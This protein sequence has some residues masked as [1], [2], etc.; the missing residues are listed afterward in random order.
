M[1]YLSFT[2]RTPA[3]APR[4]A[5]RTLLAAFAIASAVCLLGAQ[6]AR[7]Q[8]SLERELDA[9]GKVS[10]K[11]RNFHGR[12]TVVASEAQQKVSV[13]AESPARPLDEKELRTSAERGAVTVEVERGGLA[14][15]GRN[16]Y[17]ADR[18]E[19]ERDRVDLTVRVPQ[20]AR[21]RVETRGGA[22]EIVGNVESAEV[23]TDTGT[24]RA[25]VP[26]ESVALR[27]SLK[28][29]AAR[30]RFYSEIELPKVQ[31]RRG[32]VFEI[33]GRVGDKKAKKD[34]RIELDFSTER[35]V[36][37]FGVSDPASVPTDLR[38]RQLTEAARAVIRSGNRDLIDAIRKVA[39]R[40]VGDYSETLPP[41]LREPT[42]VRGRGTGH[43]TARVEQSLVSVNAS[44]TDKHGRAIG[45][46]TE[47]DFQLFEDGRPRPIQEVKAT[48]APF[49]LVLLLDV[50]GSVEERLDFIRKAALSFLNTVSPQDRIAIIS[51]RDDIQ[52]ISEFTTDRQHLAQSVKKIQAGGATALYDALAYALVHTLKPLR[53]ERTAV[54]VLSDG[55]DNRSFIPFS[56]VLEATVE[57]GALID[58]L[59]VPSGL[60]PTD[61]GPAPTASLDPIRARYLTL[62]SRAVEE[63]QRLAQVSGGVYYPI[64]R[65]DQLQ[66]AYDDVVTQ[67]RT[68]YQ[69]TYASEQGGRGEARVRVRVARDDASVRLSPSVKRD[70]P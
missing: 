64:T 32:G 55:D 5:R 29:T 67:L 49:N 47:K 50:S 18:T 1:L 42:L 52:I 26:L 58:P 20:R 19:N 60:V 22:V 23:T 56:D 34:D 4:R 37:L 45:G 62:T 69:I 39:P 36:V 28:W 51:F 13:R 38:E 8:Q 46:L 44:V 68:S 9:S 2:A 61:A 43:L 11:V 66:K 33:E 7:A 41:H 15:G 35:G 6:P 17:A 59:Y 57:S 40:L 16:V 27:Y 53:G 14:A 21:V 63:G 24:I 3:H 10:L 25:D 31:E 65:L 30:P 70:N 54:V 48:N 12:V